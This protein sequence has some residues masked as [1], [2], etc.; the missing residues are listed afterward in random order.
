MSHIVVNP[1]SAKRKWVLSYMEEVCKGIHADAVVCFGYP[2]EII[3]EELYRYR[4]EGQSYEDTV[5]E[6]ER[7]MDMYLN[8]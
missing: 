3:G 4:M 5:S 8:E 1:N 2:E 7:K 6:L